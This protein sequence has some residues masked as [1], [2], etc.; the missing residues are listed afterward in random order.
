RRSPYHGIGPQPYERPRDAG[1]LQGGIT[2][3]RG[4]NV[5]FLKKYLCNKAITNYKFKKSLAGFSLIELIL[6]VGI[7][8]LVLTF[9]LRFSWNIFGVKDRV[10]HTTE[11]IQ[12]GRLAFTRITQE[13]HAADDVRTWEGYE[14][15]DSAAQFD[16]GSANKTEWANG[17]ILSGS[18]Q[19]SGIGEFTSRVMDAGKPITWGPL[20]ALTRAPYGKALPDNEG[21]E[22]SY[23]T[24]NAAMN[25]NVLLYHFDEMSGTLVDSSEHANHGVNHGAAYD[26]SGRFQS[27][28]EFGGGGGTSQTIL[29][30]T[31]DSWI[32][33]GSA[34]NH[35]NASL[36]Q[37]YP[38]RSHHQR[39]L[40]KFD[41][42]SLPTGVTITSA[43]L[44]LME[45]STFGLPKTIS[46]HRLTHDWT[47][48]NGSSGSGAT[49]TQYD[50]SHSWGSSGGDFSPSS[51]DESLVWWN[52]WDFP[53]ID[54]WDVTNDVEKIVRGTYNNY[55]WLLKNKYE[56]NSQWYWFFQSREGT[57]HPQLVINYTSPESYVDAGNASSLMPS[58]LTAEAWINMDNAPGSHQWYGIL[59]KGDES[60]HDGYELYVGGTDNPHGSNK[61]SWAI[62]STVTVSNSSPSPGKWAHVVGTYDGSLLTLYVNGVF[63]SSATATLIS[64]TKPLYI[65]RRYTDEDHAFDG[66]LDEIAIYNRVLTPGEI[67]DHYR[68]G[69]L[70][71]RFQART[72]SS[73][74]LTGDFTG[75]NG[76]STDYYSELINDTLNPP[77]YS[78]RNLAT[79][80]YFQ[81]RATLTTDDAGLTPTLTSVTLGSRGSSFDVNPGL[82][83][84]DFPG[85][86][87]EVIV[88][89]YVQQVFL[90][91]QPFLIRTLRMKE[92][93]AVANDLTSQWVDVTN[94]SLSNRA[95]ASEAK[96]VKIN[97]TLSSIGGGSEDSLNLETAA[98]VRR[99]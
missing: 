78:L 46:V 38:R 34:S 89:T 25:D 72:G 91:G 58:Q 7:S 68:R 81:Y 90:G 83:L 14:V 76:T 79:N 64:N 88:D 35:G 95:R 66:R 94:F 1:K 6:Y 51:S 49:W 20:A 60:S 57:S 19:T 12:N 99:Q 86:G 93:E 84:L 4:R 30:P 69:V 31:S 27:A 42:S 39:S 40:V 80:R 15:D 13:I 92:G 36:L 77:T 44:Q 53:K 8:A 74:S 71:L 21:A 24:G 96:N 37:L 97:L 22:T 26:S 52:P 50:G 48:G 61:I 28:L 54:E 62:G 56:D 32:E 85:E 16:A 33:Q 63:N 82:L 23:E 5:I 73:F 11:L 17:L 98:S 59:S 41:L 29:Y 70:N 45:S 65:G 55:G 87:S 10:N 18:G 9:I 67:A 43:T 75:P 47:E 3:S 2:E